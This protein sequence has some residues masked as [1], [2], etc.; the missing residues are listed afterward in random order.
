MGAIRRC[1]RGIAAALGEAGATVVCQVAVAVHEQSGPTAT[2][3]RPSKKLPTSSRDSAAAARDSQVRL[4]LSHDRG[5]RSGADEPGDNFAG[6]EQR[7]GRHASDLIIQG[8]YG[9]GIDV[10]RYDAKARGL[11]AGNLF[12]DRRENAAGTAP[13]S[14]EVDEHGSLTGEDV[15]GERSVGGVGE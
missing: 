3:P 4:Q 11:V 14:G 1:R 13:C 15:V 2:V 7:Q 5:S 8:G 10:D 9:V 12:E 6:D